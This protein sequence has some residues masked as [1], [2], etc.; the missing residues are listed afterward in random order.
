MLLTELS[1]NPFYNRICELI[2]RKMSINENTIVYTSTCNTNNSLIEREEDNNFT[3]EEV[4][5]NHNITIEQYNN[6]NIKSII[7]VVSDDTTINIQ[8]VKFLNCNSIIPFITF[9]KVI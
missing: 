9:Y 3:V 5:S 2:S 6:K 7:E 1:N 4:L 8:F